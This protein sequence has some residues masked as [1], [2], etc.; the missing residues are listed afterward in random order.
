MKTLLAED[1]VT[2]ACKLMFAKEIEEG[3]KCSLI[4]ME[5]GK[6]IWL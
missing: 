5:G 6:A 1:L 2:D 4:Q 3:Q